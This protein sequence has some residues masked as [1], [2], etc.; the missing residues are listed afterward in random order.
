MNIQLAL[1]HA[2]G[3]RISFE[4]EMEKQAEA[5]EACSANQTISFFPVESLFRHPVP[6]Y[7]IV[8]QIFK[9]FF[10]LR[11][12]ISAPC[13]LQSMNGLFGQQRTH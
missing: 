5:A 7:Q 8:V 9:S 12:Y 10:Y 11:R 13:F 3:D 6:T 4:Q 2:P 1:T